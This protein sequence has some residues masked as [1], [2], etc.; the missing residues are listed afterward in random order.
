MEMIERHE[1]NEAWPQ[2]DFR[3]IDNCYE[4]IDLNS[5]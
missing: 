2:Y 4:I 3:P 1:Q 5:D